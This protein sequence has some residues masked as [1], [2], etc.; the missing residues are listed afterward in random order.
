MML[1]KCPDTQNKLIEINVS[2]NKSKAATSSKNIMAY[3]AIKIIIQT[4]DVVRISVVERG[5]SSEV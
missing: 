4:H 1:G 2:S 3:K 5:K